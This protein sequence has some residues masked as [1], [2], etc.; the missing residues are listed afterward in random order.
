[1]TPSELVVMRDPHTAGRL[2]MVALT[3]AVTG[4][5]PTP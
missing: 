5:F 1:M 3:A 4:H 2:G